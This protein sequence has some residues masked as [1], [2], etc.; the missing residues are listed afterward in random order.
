MKMGICVLKEEKN[1][2]HVLH[3]YGGWKVA[4]ITYSQRFNRCEK[5]A[6]ERHLYTDEIFILLKGRARLYFGE[7]ATPL[8]MKKGVAY[9]VPKCEWHS[10]SVSKGA[11][12]AIM[13]NAETGRENTEYKT[14][15]KKG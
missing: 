13:E 12:L 2:Y 8:P 1:G 11:K 4:F 14:A 15:V 10:V 6:I 9:L 5:N 7:E 3:T